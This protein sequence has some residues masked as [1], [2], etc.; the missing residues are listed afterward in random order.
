MTTIRKGLDVLFTFVVLCLFFCAPAGASTS[1][2]EIV[3]IEHN[4]TDYRTL[5]DGV[6]PGTEVHVLDAAKDGLAQMARILAGRTGMDAIHLL[7]HG[8]AGQINLGAV[9]LSNGNLQE[10]RGLLKQ[11]GSS[12]TEGGDFLVYGCEVAKGEAG[13][14][15]VNSLATLMH[16]EVAASDGLTGASQ[17]GGD[18][19]LETTSGN[20]K[21]INARP[22][23]FQEYQGLLD[24]IVFGDTS[25]EYELDYSTNSFTRTISGA[26]F[27][28][29]SVENMGA[30]TFLGKDYLLGYDVTNNITTVTIS[31]TGYTFDLGSFHYFVDSSSPAPTV[32]VHVTYASGSSADYSFTATADAEQT[33]SSFS[34]DNS[35]TTVNDVT[36]IKI[37][38]INGVSSYNFSIQDLVI[39]DVRAIPSSPTITSATYNA[40]TNLLTVTATGMSA[41]SGVTNDINV[42]KLTLTGQG[43]ASYTLTSPNVE[44]SSSTQFTVTL[45]ATDQIN[46]RGLLNKDGTSSTGGTAYN[47][48]A[49][50]DWNPANVGNADLAGN[51]V[52]VSNVQTPI[53]T[54]STYDA[55]TGVL[56]VTGTNLVKQPGATNDIDVTKLSVAG[57]GGSV[58]LTSNTANVE[59]TSATS[60]TV[61]LGSTDKAA[62]NAK[63]DKNGTSS[64]GGTTYNLAADDDWNGPITGGSIADTTG[65]GITVSGIAASYTVTYNG[66]GSTNGSV[67]TDGNSYASGNTVTVKSNSG[68][69][70]RSGYVFAG[71]NTQADGNGTDYAASGSATFTMGS[72]NVTLYAKWTVVSGLTV[73]TAAATG[74][75]PD[76]AT[77]NGTSTVSGAWTSVGFAYGPTTSYGGF[78]NATPRILNSG[79]G[80]TAVSAMVTGL[81]CNTTYH[82]RVNGQDNGGNLTNG[83]DLTFTTSA[84][85]APGAPTIGTAAAGDSKAVVTFTPPASNGGATITSY[86][87]TSSPGNITATGTASPIVVSGLSNGQPYTFTV[88]ATN[89]P[90]V[91]GNGLASAASNAVTPSVAS[92]GIGS[93]KITKFALNGSNQPTDATIQVAAANSAL[94]TGAFTIINNTTP[95]ATVAVINASYA[96][97]VYTLTASGMNVYDT[98]TLAVTATGYDTHTNNSVL[99]GRPSQAADLDLVNEPNIFTSFTRTLTSDGVVTIG[100]ST[101]AANAVLYSGPVYDAIDG[102]NGNPD[103]G[104]AT[105]LVGIFGKA[106]DGATCVKTLRTDATILQVAADSLIDANPNMQETIQGGKAA[107]DASISN[108]TYWQTLALLPMYGQIASARQGN[109]SRIL[110]DPADRFRII[111]WYDS[112][113]G[114]GNCTGTPM[115][116]Q[117]LTVKVEYSGAVIS[118]TNAAVPSITTQPSN[119]SVSING[120]ATVS[121]SASGGTTLSYQWYRNTTNSNSGGTIISGAAGNS[122]A[123]P[124]AAAGT[125]YYYCVV[126]NT[127]GVSNQ[128]AVV[129]NAVKVVTLAAQTIGTVSSTPTILVAGVGTT[130]SATATS[131][132]TVGFTSLTPAVCTV[133]GT[134]VT[135]LTAGVCTIA[136]DQAGDALYD[137]A[138]QVI[139]N[140]TVANAA[141]M[142]HLIHNATITDFSTIQD[143]VDATVDGDTIRLDAGTFVEQL[144]ITKNITLQG[145]GQEQSII[146]SPLAASLVQSGG[147]WRNLRDKT[148]YAVIGIKTVNPGTVTI[149]DLT[150]D[151]AVQG[152]INQPAN[153]YSFVGIGAL[154]SN[155]TVD[156]VTITGVRDLNLNAA[157]M[158]PIPDSSYGAT[159]T[160]GADSGESIFAE[161]ADGAGE[162]TLVVRNSTMDDIQKDGILAWGPTL[163]VDIHDNTIQ[164]RKT[165]YQSINGIQIGSSDYSG[166]GGGDR[167]GTK[168]NISNN[169]ILDLGMV[170]PVGHTTSGLWF[171]GWVGGSTGILVW[172]AGE[173]ATVTGNTITRTGE[174]SWKLEWY[175]NSGIDTYNSKNPVVSNNTIT[176][177]DYGILEEGAVTASVFTASGNILDGNTVAIWSAS[178]NDRI[179]LNDTKSEVIGYQLTG[180]G[181]DTL[182]NFSVGDAIYVNSVDGTNG[183]N[184]TGGTVTAGDGSTVAAKSVQVSVSGST[185]TLHV[186]TDGVSGAQLQI[187]LAGVYT[188]A[189]FILNGAYIS[190]AKAAQ[191][192]TFTNP[193]AQTFGAAPTLTA[194]TTSGLTPTF[195]SGTT[196]VCTITSS[197]VLTLVAGGSCTIYAD[198]PGNGTYNPAAQVSQ[199]FTVNKF[200]AIV[201]LGSLS[202]SYDGTVKAVTVTTAPVGLA[203]IITYDGSTSV[204]TAV[205]SYAVVATVN[206]AGY[207]GFASG[208]LVI[209]KGIQ[210]ITFPPLAVGHPGDADSDPGAVSSAGLAITY[211]SSDPAVASITGGKIRP[212]KIGTSVITASQPG[213]DVWLAASASQTFT[214]AYGSNPP[215]LTLSALSDGAVT[216]ETTQNISGMV[217]DPNG[218][219]SVTVNGITVQINPDGSFSY[220]VQLLSGS[221]VIT[222]IVTNNAGVSTTVT[223]TII[224]DSTAPKLT[225]AYPPDNA[226]AIRQFV[227]VTGS[228][229]S[230]F[231]GSTTAKSTDKSV[232]AALDPTLVVTYSVNGS[233]AQTASLTDS[234]Y[235][236]TTS[237]GTGMNTIKV[238]AANGAGQKVEAK[239]TVTYQPAFSLAVAD[240]AADMRIPLSSYLLTGN[241]ADNPTAVSIKIVMNGQ[242]IAT[243]QVPENGGIFRQLLTFSEDKVYQVSVT[244]TDTNNNSLTVQRNIIHTVPK[245]ATG[246]AAPFTIVDALFALQMAV[247]IMQPSSDQTLRMD[248][249]PMVNGVSYGDGKVDVEDAMVI[250]RMAVGLIK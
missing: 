80:A 99:Y 135:G 74:V 167:R 67:P 245:T 27:T 51:G 59:I 227:T 37:S 241:V 54:S 174:K 186:N 82:F 215:T 23:S 223:R 125:M 193:G 152:N 209:G 53:I 171:N 63:L 182:T 219:R 154:N 191:T 115:D 58:T 44:I 162:H 19:I 176:G 106:P 204:P 216:T 196:G 7:S 199:T 10:Y 79:A 159:H 52:T 129:S 18:W 229:E 28:F 94:G 230:L 158:D 225:V 212:L 189:N 49:A 173:G 190:F 226:I 131:G 69:I 3:F 139:R 151:G 105:R 172:E 160:S 239:R 20:Y 148:V 183:W 179:T 188:P 231:T 31:A 97:N 138:P 181:S 107:Y 83:S 57:Q 165:F 161:S 111:E 141:N 26:T 50:A 207:A 108:T 166:S 156:G 96:N 126:T 247:G 104:T 6:T 149:T 64:T 146:K 210:T 127:D 243:L 109:G 130:L 92:L 235:S 5:R 178:G 91:S 36:S 248:V 29:S 244:G 157:S 122:Y 205:G 220:P 33:V 168:G 86:T 134:T 145:A 150:V 249:A 240:P 200:A 22:L 163:T 1:P 233:A 140:F 76:S 133:S 21:S 203:V 46:V 30:S 184:F 34:F 60:F 35:E 42:G 95:S 143:A 114:S 164:G 155:L 25:H 70:T 250:L 40:G 234:T 185:T 48:A 221:N 75:G 13:R 90:A 98:Y 112:I 214:V 55:G 73:T 88:T 232:A 68:G 246:E 147:T 124:T 153:T 228:I 45:N 238:F 113:D 198:Q 208:T 202:A 84:C 237:L 170:I 118:Q 11:I 65:N 213:N 169:T 194:T 77:L 100:N 101:H 12:L 218:I 136:A 38:S 72:T 81:T 87:V 15:L 121:L 128:T 217:S 120:T 17:L 103:N 201:T 132:L 195:T 177:F 9:T 180:N 117:R 211:T 85:I 175:S 2:K 192:I 56:T 14:A 32:T 4:V 61:T 62:V 66:N 242:N 47:I 43:G 142:V 119:I 137:T 102:N 197:G 144:T 93:I 16:A 123:A 110:V 224:L 24:T 206:N 236:F 39:T 89:A 71:W 116:V 41:T 8:A 187:N 78:A 222:V